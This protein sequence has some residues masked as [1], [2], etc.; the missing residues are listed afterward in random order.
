VDGFPLLP[1][2]ISEG[3]SVPV[4]IIPSIG[5]AFTWRAGCMSHGPACKP[6]LFL[7]DPGSKILLPVCLS[8]CS[9][10]QQVGICRRTAGYYTFRRRRRAAFDG[11]FCPGNYRFYGEAD[12]SK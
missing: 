10:W 12:Q 6:G 5:T 11:V 2:H 3:K 4:L 9:A 8:G 7:K 1:I